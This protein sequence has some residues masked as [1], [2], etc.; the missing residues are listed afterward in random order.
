MMKNITF[1]CVV[2]RHTFETQHR[3]NILVFPSSSLRRQSRGRRGKIVG[4][5]L[6]L[7]DV[8]SYLLF[9]C[10]IVGQLL[11]F[12]IVSRLLF[13]ERCGEWERSSLLGFA[14][15]E[16][17]EGV[18]SCCRAAKVNFAGFFALF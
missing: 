10:L 11:V 5:R 13:I 7:F 6:L 15:W 12:F 8:A 18:F 4:N 3:C 2:Q 17:S 1:Y 16:E 14:N 9:A